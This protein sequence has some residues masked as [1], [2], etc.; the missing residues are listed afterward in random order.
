M[1][2]RF[3]LATISLL[4]ATATALAAGAGREPGLFSGYMFGDMY[5]V[6]SDHDRAIEDANGFW[7]R[8]IYFTY[9]RRLDDRTTTRLRYEMTGEGDFSTRAKLTPTLKDAYVRRD[10]GGGHRLTFGIS[11]TPAWERLEK[12]WGYRSVEKTPL[13]LQKF[14]SSRDFGVALA[15]ALAS[16]GRAWYHLMVGNGNGNASETDDGKKVMASLGT[17]LG[18]HLE[19]EAYADHD[20]RP[21]RKSRAVVQG[22]AA[23]RAA[24]WRL[25]VQYDHVTHHR[26]PDT[27]ARTWDVLSAWGAARLSAAIWLFGRVDSVSDPNPAV[28]ENDYLP[29]APDASS[30]LLLTGVDWAVSPL[31]HVM[32]NVEVVVY[33][34]A[35]GGADPHTDVLPRVTVFYRF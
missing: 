29:F 15:G 4:F 24:S 30:T 13:D 17:R 10:L 3:S 26:G 31:L 6:A 22:Y 14:G 18:E 12:A 2:N 1:R 16:D 23:W 21:G 33:D 32:P 28:T 20:T 7:F 19:V 34:A 11:P 8:R 5:W 27:A 35:G 25:G 9:D